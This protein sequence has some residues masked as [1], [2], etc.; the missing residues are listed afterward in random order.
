VTQ[1]VELLLDERADAAVRRQWNLLSD[2]GLPSERRADPRP[3]VDH[4]CPHITLYAGDTLAGDAEDRLVELVG[5]LRLELQLGAVM[6][7]GPRRGRAILVRQVTPS[8]PLLQLQELVA[9]VCGAEAD[10]QFG[11]GRWAP[12]VTLARRLSTGQVSDALAALDWTADRPVPVEVTACR[13]W[14][15][16]RKT[17][18]LV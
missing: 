1:S 5:G 3:V 14:D 18:W 10:G 2:A 13:R 8:V 7:F 4:H 12:H 15:G 6:V 17:A 11:A 9:A 16:S